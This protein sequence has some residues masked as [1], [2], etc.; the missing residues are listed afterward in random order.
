MASIGSTT[1]KAI[2]EAGYSPVITAK[3]SNAEGLSDSITEYFKK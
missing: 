1:T 3:M 2:E